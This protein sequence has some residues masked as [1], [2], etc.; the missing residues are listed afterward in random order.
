MV[1]CNS[2]GGAFP[3]KPRTLEGLKCSGLL[4]HYA[5][6]QSDLSGIFF[7]RGGKAATVEECFRG[8]NL[9]VNAKRIYLSPVTCWKHQLHL[10]F[11]SFIECGIGDFQN[12]QTIQEWKSRHIGIFKNVLGTIF[13]IGFVFPMSFSLKPALSPGL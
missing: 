11:S 8:I 1:F 6:V 7:L 4:S 2:A 9:S 13:T 10:V 12:G 5:F 3:P